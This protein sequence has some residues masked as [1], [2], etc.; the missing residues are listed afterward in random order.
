MRPATSI[1]LP[2][3]PS[4]SCPSQP[5]LPLISL[6]VAFFSSPLPAPVPLLLLPFLV[7]PNPLASPLPDPPSPLSFILPHLLSTPRPAPKQRRAGWVAPG[8]GPA[9]CSHLLCGRVDSP[10]PAPRLE[11]KWVN[12]EPLRLCLGADGGPGTS[13]GAGAAGGR[14]HSRGCGPAGPSSPPG[15]RE[16]ASLRDAQAAAPSVPAFH[17]AGRRVSPPGL[18]S[19]YPTLPP[20]VSPRTAQAGA[21][22]WSTPL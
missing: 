10:P 13:A 22:P 16:A 17:L 1:F 6:Q 15:P 8:S 14:L 12:A 9:L 4:P 18:G 19:R 5:S 11:G 21:Q 2:L 7:P 3:L 20:S